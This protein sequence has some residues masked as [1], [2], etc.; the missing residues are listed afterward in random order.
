[1]MSFLDLIDPAQDFLLIQ[2]FAGAVIEKTFAD[3]VD[4]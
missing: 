3:W 2:V 4:A 1:M